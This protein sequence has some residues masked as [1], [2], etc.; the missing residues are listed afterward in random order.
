M[1][2]GF[3]SEGEVPFGVVGE[4]QGERLANAKHEKSMSNSADRRSA[5]IVGRNDR[6]GRAAGLR[7]EGDLG[8]SAREHEGEGSTFDLPRAVAVHGRRFPR[9]IKTPSHGASNTLPKA[10]PCS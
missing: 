2:R 8:A 7:V 6:G 1:T 4:S 3:P 9:R 10:E 5:A